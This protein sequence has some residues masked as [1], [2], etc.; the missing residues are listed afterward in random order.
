MS[1]SG[2]IE[3]VY[4]GDCGLCVA[5][6]G[7]LGRRDKNERINA[8]PSTSCTWG[9][10]D[11]S[12]FLTTVVARSDQGVATA[13]TA[14]ATALSVLPGIWGSLGRFTLRANNVM[15]LKAFHDWCYYLVAKHRIAISRVLVRCHLLDATCAVPA[16]K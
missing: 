3:I 1:I 12:L 7:W 5:S 6:V 15:I 8:Y 2:V 11:S 14:V 16:K 9:D 4:D 13:S 10:V